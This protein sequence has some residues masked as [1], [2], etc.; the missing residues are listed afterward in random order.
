M[1]APRPIDDA[2]LLAYL[3]GELDPARAAEVDRALM[4]DAALAH[5][6]EQHRLLGV[7][8]TAAFAPLLSDPVPEALLRAARAP[9]QVTD[10]AAFRARRAPTRARP[11]WLNPRGLGLIAAS[12]LAI[13]IV[14]QTVLAPPPPSSLTEQS[15][16]LVA[17]GPL[18]HAL[19][20]QLA[21]AG[22]VRGVRVNLTFR[23]HDGAI[24]RTF[25]DQATAG[26]ACRDGARWAVKAVFGGAGGQGGGY[27]M[28][29]SGDPRL[30]QWAI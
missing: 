28:A 22:V 16:R 29:S 15:G 21:S 30:M 20:V 13:V 9:A 11:A 18:A 7:R 6:L 19:D 8:L 25:Q 10:L 26:L 14:G 27:R 23:D 3:D 24:C 1:S 2:T 12:L 17:S 4:D 5:R